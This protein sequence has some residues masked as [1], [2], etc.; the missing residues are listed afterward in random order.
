MLILDQGSPIELGQPAFLHRKARSRL[1]PPNPPFATTGAV[2]FS[3]H[4]NG[5][6][7]I[8]AF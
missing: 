8:E 3:G 7:R 2:P 4:Y 1:C 5:I 6:D